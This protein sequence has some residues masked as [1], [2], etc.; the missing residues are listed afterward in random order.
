MSRKSRLILPDHYRRPL[1]PARA[2]GRPLYFDVP[3]PTQ[4]PC[5]LCVREGAGDH[6]YGQNEVFMNDPANSP[7]NDES[8]YYV[9]R[10]HLPH[11]AVIYNPQ[12]GTC[13]NKEGGDTWRENAAPDDPK[14]WEGVASNLKPDV[15]G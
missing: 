13:R 10:G 12:D 11:D 3:K 7:I 1:T 4:A 6:F 14:T 15:D 5:L 9:C 2:D 8:V